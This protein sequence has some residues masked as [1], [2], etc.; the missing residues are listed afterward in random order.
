MMIV[1]LFFVWE[2]PILLFIIIPI[3]IIT[4]IVYLRLTL[5]LNALLNPLAKNPPNGAMRE[6]KSAKARECSCIG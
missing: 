5:T 6:L 4:I 3:I 2:D 1:I